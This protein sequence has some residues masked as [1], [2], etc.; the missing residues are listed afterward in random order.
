ML[1]ALGTVVEV[2]VGH[3]AD[4]EVTFSQGDA[5]FLE[6][7]VAGLEVSAELLDFFV[8]KGSHLVEGIVGLVYQYSYFSYNFG[9]I[10]T[11]G[12]AGGVVGFE[13]TGEVHVDV[14][15]QL[16]QALR[17]LNRVDVP[18][19]GVGVGGDEG[20]VN[21]TDV[22]IAIVGSVF[23]RLGS[24]FATAEDEAFYREVLLL[25]RCRRTVAANVSAR[26]IF[27]RKHGHFKG[28][29]HLVGVLESVFVHAIGILHIQAAGH[30]LQTV[31]VV[32]VYLC[33]YGFKFI[34][35]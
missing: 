28:F 8:G 23:E 2:T 19:V 4:E 9:L 27:E 32:T 10:V 33:A 3:V 11:G 25:V 13:R 5:A 20:R 35:T 18:H 12:I 30:L 34:D 22:H 24:H 15:V 7:L 31:E 26:Y 14:V 21:S 16:L 1:I 6:L 29:A 17:V